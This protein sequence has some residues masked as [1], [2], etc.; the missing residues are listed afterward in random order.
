MYS[1]AL[2]VPRR[3]VNGVSLPRTRGR[4]FEGGLGG[5]IPTGAEQSRAA[6]FSRTRL[7][8]DTLQ[9]FKTALIPTCCLH[10][11]RLKMA[12]ADNG[13]Y[14]SFSVPATGFFHVT[15]RVFTIAMTIKFA[16]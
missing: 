10:L 7:H 13:I 5:Q 6:L 2:L 4:G 12:W 9:Y 3:A 1:C 14:L 15:L 11:L 16:L 8:C